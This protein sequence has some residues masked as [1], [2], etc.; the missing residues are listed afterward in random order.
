MV[1]HCY[2]FV[3]VALKCEPL[4][5]QLKRI[6]RYSGNCGDSSRNRFRIVF[7]YVDRQMSYVSRYFVM[8]INGLIMVMLYYRFVD[9]AYRS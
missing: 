9:I 1:V 5:F 4:F 3:S 7:F 8:V 2:R 6:S